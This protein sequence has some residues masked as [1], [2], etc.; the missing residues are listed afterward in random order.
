MVFSGIV[1]TVLATD[2]VGDVHRVAV[3]RVLH[4]GR[5]PQRTLGVGAVGL[6]RREPRRRRT[7]PRR[8]RRRAG[9]WR[10]PP[11]PSR[12]PACGSPDGLEPLV[13]LGVDAGDE[14][15]RHRVDLGQVLAVGLGL[16]EALEV[17]VHD[18]VVAVEAEDQRDVDADALGEHVGDRRGALGGGRDLDEQVRPV[19]LGPQLLGRARWSPSASWARPGATS[20][21]TRPST[22]PLASNG[23]L[24]HVAGVAD[25][26][27][28]DRED[29]L[30]DVRCPRRR[31]RGPGRRTARRRRGRAA[32]I[33]G[34]VVTPDDGAVS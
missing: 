15:R 31:A 26:G 20:M 24:E 1:L 7:S 32:K 4:P 21:E 17:G 18:R 29:R 8:P 12:L 30:V 19:D 14:E 25:V 10:C 28:G 23:R 9:R 22:P 34:F 3:V 11:G 16:L 6:E 27:G 2:E 33:V 5:R 13:D